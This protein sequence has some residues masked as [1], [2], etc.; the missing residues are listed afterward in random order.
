[1]STRLR[2][3]LAGIHIE[4]STFSPHATRAEDFHVTR[5]TDLLAR[6]DWL[7]GPGAPWAQDIEWVPLV[8]ARALPGGP[9]DPH[10]Y[11]NWRAEI[12]AGLHDQGPFDAVLLDIHGAMSVQGRT[13]AEGDLA[14]A[15]RQAIGPEPLVGAAMDLHGNI[16]LAFFAACDLMTCYRTAPHIDVWETRK[17]AA[18]TLVESVRSGMRPHKALVHV[19]V[20]LPGEKTSTRDEP[21]RSLYARVP[22]VEARPGVL[23]ASIW[24]GFAWADEPR[25]RASVVVTGVDAE[26]VREGALDL[27]RSF[28]EVRDQFS[29]VA[30]TGTMDECLVTAVAAAGKAG[31]TPFFISDSGDNPGAGGADDVTYALSRLVACEP[32]IS[33][34]VHAV[35]ASIVDPEAVETLHQAGIGELITLS[36]GGRVDGR[37]PGPLTL[38]GTVAALADDPQGGRSAVLRCGGLQVVLTSR[39]TQYATLDRYR[40]LGIDVGA[41]DIVV[42]KIGYLEPELHEAARGW[43]LALTPGGVDQDIE[44]LPYRALVRPVY[45][46]D[47]DFD[48][49]LTPVMG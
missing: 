42:V 19:P 16:S 4:S 25:S 17:R 1:M 43:R 40:R 38:E 7:A 47:R 33:G 45:P 11:N 24:V 27:A 49:D 10:A 29:F 46:L 13:D 18:R 5:G 35:H 30:P 41:Q 3:A 15:V 2:I 48:A 9:V 37:A 39:R 20:L 21:A 6:Y 36:V 28:W 23:D 12:V 26:A 14:E 8:H 44:R 34:Q 31:Q 32:V 22:E